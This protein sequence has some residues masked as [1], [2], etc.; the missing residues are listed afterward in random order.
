M[1]FI[2]IIKDLTFAEMD[3]IRNDLQK[4]NQSVKLIKKTQLLWSKYIKNKLRQME[5]EIPTLPSSI[6]RLI[7]PKINDYRINYEEMRKNFSKCDDAFTFNLE[8][9]KL[10]E[11]SNNEKNGKPSKNSYT[12]KDKLIQTANMVKNQGEYIKEANRTAYETENIVIS[13]QNELKKNKETIQ[14]SVNNVFFS[15]NFINF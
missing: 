2:K 12:S 15:F 14:R 13:V 5:N 6:Q 3:K 1:N 11:Q 8:K 4:A 7:S 9:A 10:L